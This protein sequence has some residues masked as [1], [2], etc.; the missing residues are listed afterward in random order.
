MELGFT[1]LDH[2]QALL[3]DWNDLRVV[4]DLAGIP[5]VIAARM[6]PVRSVKPRTAF[7][8]CEC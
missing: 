4:P 7:L 1:S 8:A 2:V 3:A 5:R 6:L